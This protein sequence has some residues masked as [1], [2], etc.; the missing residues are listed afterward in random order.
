MA[1]IVTLD[2]RM[3]SH[4]QVNVLSG[5]D[6]RTFPTVEAFLAWL[7]DVHRRVV[8]AGGTLRITTARLS[9]ATHPADIVLRERIG[10]SSAGPCLA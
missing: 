7:L 10:A 5:K 2:V 1:T 3:V 4:A 6:Q 9:T 8:E